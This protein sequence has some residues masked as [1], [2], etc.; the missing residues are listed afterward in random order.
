MKQAITITDPALFPTRP[1]SAKAFFQTLEILDRASQE[2][3]FSIDELRGPRRFGDLVW[4]RHLAMTAMVRG[5][6]LSLT[7]IGKLFDGRHHTSVIHAI[8]K[9]ERE[10]SNRPEVERLLQEWA[11][12]PPKLP[13]RTPTTRRGTK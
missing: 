11:G 7:S 13:P 6:D 2:S 3:G 12:T 1:G 8:R 10:A 5:T 4:A 9:M